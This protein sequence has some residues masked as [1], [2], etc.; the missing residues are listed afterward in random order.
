MARSSNWVGK[1]IVILLVLGGAGAGGWYYFGGKAATPPRIQSASVQR[2]AIIQAVTATGQLETMVKTDVSSQISGRITEVHVDYNSPVKQGDVL[3]RL[4]PATYEAAVTQA[5]NELLN[6]KANYRLVRANA[7]RSAVLF[8]QKLIS[9]ADLDQVQAQLEQAEVQIKIREAAL[10]SRRTDL[11]RCTL[12]APIDGI[13]IDRLADVGK[14][15]AASL[16][17]PTLFTIVN[18]LT[19]MQINAAVAEAD[20][21]NVKLGQDVEFTVDAFPGEKFGGRI[22]QIRNLPVTA[23]NVVVYATIIE[24]ANE[25]LKLKPGM[26]AN[27]QIIIE[28][29][30]NALRVP[31]AAMRARIPDEF[32]PPPPATPAA[33]PGTAQAAP[34]AAAAPADPREQFRA[35]MRE[36]GGDWEKARALAAERGIQLP[37]RRGGGG[38]GGGRRE[39][40]G[41]SAATPTIVTRTLYKLIED[42]PKPKIEAVTVKLGITDGS[43]TE[44]LEGL[45]EKDVVVTS[46]TVPGA[47]ASASTAPT[48]SSPFGGGPRRF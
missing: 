2:G 44:V 40:S 16:N 3:A 21:G 15:V 32:L 5:E 43:V 24:V 1:T 34:A 17:A 35:L 18:D 45:Q 10:E 41:S 6:A 39:R 30:D 4:D 25:R 14:T 19:K 7:D 38:E 9:Q 13:V 11:S 36:T 42:G 33:A 31:N 48:G 27:V 8:G 29:R 23:Q 37:E 12:Y 20:I 22:I 28:R 26:T 47:A 46:F